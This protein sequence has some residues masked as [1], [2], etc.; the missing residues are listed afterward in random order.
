MAHNLHVP[1]GARHGK[2]LRNDTLLFR[3]LDEV[4][5][6]NTQAAAWARREL[7]NSTGKIIH[8]VQRLHDNALNT[9]IVTP[10]L[11]HQLGVVQTLNPD[12]GGARHLSRG[13]LHRN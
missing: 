5:N 2:R 13:V 3:T 11:L 7:T 9:Q 4:V 6:Q 8:A 1:G 12:A 10:D